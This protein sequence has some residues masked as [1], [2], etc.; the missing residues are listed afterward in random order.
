MT[1]G[2]DDGGRGRGG[3][4]VIQVDDC[5]AAVYLIEAG[6]AD[7]LNDGGGAVKALAATRLARWDSS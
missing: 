4:T 6:T 2:S 5:G 3:A 7:V 1:R